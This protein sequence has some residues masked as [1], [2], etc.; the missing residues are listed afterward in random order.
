MAGTGKFLRYVYPQ[1]KSSCYAHVGFSELVGRSADT[2]VLLVG[3]DV[4]SRLDTV[5][6]S[7]LILLKKK[8][9]KQSKAMVRHSTSPGPY[10]LCPILI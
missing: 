4:I 10:S 5:D 7:N 1:R 2:K 6:L 8:D 3:A 9:V